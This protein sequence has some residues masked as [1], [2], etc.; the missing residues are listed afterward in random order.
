MDQGAEENERV[1]DSKQA[2]G[3]AKSPENRENIEKL[4]DKTF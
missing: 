1:E 2:A 3:R 4:V